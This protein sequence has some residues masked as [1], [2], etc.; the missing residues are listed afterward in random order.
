MYID[1]HAHISSTAIAGQLEV[2]SR[3]EQ[4]RIVVFDVGIDVKTSRGVLAFAQKHPRVFP[5]VG[6]HPYYATEG[7]LQSQAFK[8]IVKEH[9]SHIR[10]I[11]EIGLD[12]KSAELF[13]TQKQAFERMLEIAREYQLPVVV[14]SRGYF[15]EL[16]NIL[17]AY[18]PV[19]VLFHCFSYSRGE[20]DILLERGYSVSFS[21]NIFKNSLLDECIVHVPIDRLMLETDCPYMYFAGASLGQD[22]AS[23]GHRPDKGNRRESNPLH[24]KDVFK[25]VAGL[26]Q[27]EESRLAEAVK[28]NVM[29]FFK[30][31]EED[32]A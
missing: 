9:R 28:S 32:V 31:S 7:V 16:L 6:V 15:M 14:H 18:S 30:L 17:D 2:I 8:D 20:M 1:T 5:I 12:S 25:K 26:R 27:V 3:I 22:T 21:L 13:P 4:E 11:G 10:A 29:R 19:P 24:I 23:A